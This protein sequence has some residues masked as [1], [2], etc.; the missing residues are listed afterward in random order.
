[1]CI[2]LCIPYTNCHRDVHI[3]MRCYSAFVSGS[4]YVLLQLV[5]VSDSTRLVIHRCSC[6]CCRVLRVRYVFIT[7]NS[8]NLFQYLVLLNKQY[9][10]MAAR[11]IFYF[12][13]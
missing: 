6:P 1:M 11:T 4:E 10:R 12:I 2:Y 5:S 3:F 7:N 8:C 13:F 9:N